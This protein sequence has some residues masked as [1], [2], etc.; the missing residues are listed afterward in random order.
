M[1]PPPVDDQQQAEVEAWL[2]RAG[3]ASARLSDNAT[4]AASAAYRGVTDWYDDAQTAAA[5][6][7][8]ADIAVAASVAAAGAAS[9]H[10][11]AVVAALRPTRATTVTSPP[12]DYARNAAPEQVYARPAEVYRRRFA[13]TGDDRQAID[14]AMDRIHRL[15]ATDVSLAER[16][17]ATR[18]MQALGVHQF[19]R[20]VRPELART[21]SCGLCLAN[22]TRVYSTT[23]LMP[24]HGGCHCIPMPIVGDD[25]PGKRFN[26]LDITRLYADAGSTDAAALRRTRYRVEDHGELGPVLVDAQHGFRGPDDLGSGAAADAAAELPELRLVLTDLER[27]HAAGEPLAA[28]LQYQRRRIAFLRRVA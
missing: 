2:D 19:R 8:A 4:R 7:A 20:V 16:A 21:G 28:A 13:V 12:Q 26:D 24:M 1:I 5:A 17:A 6:A 27:R 25:D 14:A 11:A 22:A 15:L 3:A 10:T 23:V 9:L 18:Q